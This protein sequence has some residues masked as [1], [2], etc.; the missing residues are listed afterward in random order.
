MEESRPSERDMMGGLEKPN[1]RCVE[2]SDVRSMVRDLLVW[3]RELEERVKV[4]E[5][6]KQGER[7]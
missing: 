7:P 3:F 4:L 5:E 6:K 1:L 2:D